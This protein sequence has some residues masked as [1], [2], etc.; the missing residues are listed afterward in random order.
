MAEIPFDQ[1]VLSFVCGLRE[2]ARRG[3]AFAML[4]A[5]FD[6]SGTS[7][8]HLNVTV[9]G[10]LGTTYDWMAF[11]RAWEA[12]LNEP[13]R[14]PYLHM[15]HVIDE[16]ECSPWFGI[17]EDDRLAR[18][19]RFALLT[20]GHNL[21]PICTM[22]NIKATA[23]ARIDKNDNPTT[24]AHMIALRR[25]VKESAKL[26]NQLGYRDGLTFYLDCMGAAKNAEFR[27]VANGVADEMQRSRH[28]GYCGVSRFCF[29]SEERELPL[30]AADLLSWHNNRFH[31]TDR[32]DLTDL[33][34]RA[35]LEL[36]SVGDFPTSIDVPT[37][38]V[39]IKNLLGTSGDE[40]DRRRCR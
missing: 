13:P 4:T 20:R 8:K 22:A 9:A 40:D 12:E 18:I 19:R 37:E 21:H 27:R 14:I 17:A 3:H 33:E 39:S 31:Q 32:N 30:Q 5:Y 1:V 15:T 11:S 24:L 28:V 10:F 7:G 38:P 16:S 6:E 36:R 34:K 29:A 23:A 2:A 26:A 35:Y 25:A